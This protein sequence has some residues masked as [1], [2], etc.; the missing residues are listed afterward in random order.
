M[1]TLEEARAKIDEDNV[2]L[3]EYEEEAKKK[4][5]RYYLLAFEVEVL[6]DY[7]EEFFR[8]EIGE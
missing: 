6:L 1:M 8:E 7:I 5:L 2:I 4:D 3:A